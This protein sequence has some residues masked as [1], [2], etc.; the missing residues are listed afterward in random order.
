MRIDH[1]APQAV[2]DRLSVT[3]HTLLKQLIAATPKQAEI[4]V[5]NNVNDLP[6]AKAVLKALTVAVCYLGKKI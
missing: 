6:T 1:Q 3:T 5:E 2:K 4:W